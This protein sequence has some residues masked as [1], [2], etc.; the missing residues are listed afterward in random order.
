VLQLGCS[1]LDRA[2]YTLIVN[3]LWNCL[4]SC[5]VCSGDHG[6][7]IFIWIRPKLFMVAN[8][9]QAAGRQWGLRDLRERF[10]SCGLVG[11]VQSPADSQR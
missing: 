10:V 6:K 9:A 7:V 3:T 2:V 5:S 8:F 1:A 4:F 11:G